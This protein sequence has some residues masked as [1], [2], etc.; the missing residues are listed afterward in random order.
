MTRVVSAVSCLGVAEADQ[1]A[2]LVAVYQDWWVVSCLTDCKVGKP[3]LLGVDLRVGTVADGI[4][5]KQA[6]CMF[7]TWVSPMFG[8]VAD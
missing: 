4:A 8:E 7:V 1:G 2:G 5:G 6:A 3:V